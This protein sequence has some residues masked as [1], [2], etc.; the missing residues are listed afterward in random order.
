MSI[1]QKIAQLLAESKKLEAKEEVVEE[2]KVE[3]VVAEEQQV[4]EEQVADE[5]ITLG[6]LFEGEE[7]SEEFKSKA[8]E[9]FEAAVT[10]RVKQEVAKIEESAAEALVTES[11]ELKEGLVDK[12]DGYL[13]Y[14]VEQW[15]QKNEL[16]LDRGIKVEIFESFVSGMKDL[17]E[18]HYIDVPEEK[19]DLMESVDAKA[20]KL[21]EQVDALTAKNVELQ[22]QLK[23]IAKETQIAEAS[24]GLSDLEVEKFKA[25]A[26]ELAYDDEESFAK[27]LALVKESIAKAPK[28]KAVVESVVTDT[29]VALTEEVQ[30]D[31][32]MKKYLNAIKPR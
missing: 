24:A 14:V 29:P 10:A 27:K 12:V 28:A 22:A 25:L 3:E 20:K 1:E 30:V 16:A 18:S 11:E 4:S 2:Q 6:A 7:F 8:A 21:E 17:L 31:P 26:E 32:S 19:F 15:M 9:I 13:D 5:K 23:T